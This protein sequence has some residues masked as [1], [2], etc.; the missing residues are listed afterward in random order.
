[1][2]RAV[3]VQQHAKLPPHDQLI[4]NLWTNDALHDHHESVNKGATVM[5]IVGK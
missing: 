4:M 2:A 5:W 1:M 3:E